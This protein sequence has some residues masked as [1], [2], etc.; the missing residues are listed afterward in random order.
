MIKT[1]KFWDFLSRNYDKPEDIEKV[2]QYDSIQ[3]IYEY[4]RPDDV[5]LDFGCATGT[6]ACVIADKVKSVHGIDISS[7]MIQIAR[8][9][10][11]ERN[12]KN[13]IFSTDSIINLENKPESYH[14]ILAFSVLHL[15]ENTEHTIN[16]IYSLLK[17][18]GYFFSLTPCL[19]EI[20]ILYTGL[21][22]LRKVKIIPHIQCYTTEGL[23]QL[24]TQ[25]GFNILHRQ[26]FDNNPM[27]YFIVAQKTK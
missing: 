16:K 15:I 24:I 5:I 26:C 27:E 20:K 25:E 14:S 18:G 7:K 12:I 23:N 10:A 22:M 13:I 17:P 4:V 6:V 21:S 19:K 8:N 2:Y 3:T 9:R 1:E 11:M